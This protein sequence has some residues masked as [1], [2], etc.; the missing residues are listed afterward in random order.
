MR[1]N[2]R[3]TALPL[4]TFAT[5][6][7]AA[8]EVH[9]LSE[10]CESALALSAAPNHLQQ[11]AG[12]FVLKEHGYERIRKSANGFNCIV[13]RNHRDAIVPI[14]FGAAS[15]DANLAA[16]LDGGRQI[17]NGASFEEMLARREQS[18]AAGAYA[19]PGP[20]ISYMVSDFNYIYNS[21]ANAMLKVGPH[22]MF[23]APGLSAE[24]IGAD[25]SAMSENRGLPMINEPGPHGFM[26][27]FIEKPSSSDGVEAVCSGELPSYSNLMTFPN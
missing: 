22:L 20:G 10:T 16:I 5:S 7:A 15:T 4:L 17:R 27:S 11:D 2:I 23:H 6:L 3:Y 24:D 21:A 1:N 19:R 13:E 8:A 25:D 26:V 9:S 14:C 12:I 18:L